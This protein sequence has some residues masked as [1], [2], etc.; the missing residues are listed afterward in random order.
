MLIDHGNL[1]I[2]FEHTVG[3]SKTAIAMDFALFVQVKHSI[4]ANHHVLFHDVS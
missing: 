1:I 3:G 4:S 2:V